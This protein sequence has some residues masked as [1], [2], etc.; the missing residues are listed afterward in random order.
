M[1]EFDEIQVER[2]N[3]VGPDGTLRFVLA[4]EERLPPPILGGEEVGKR[5]GDHG[6]MFV[7]YNQLGDECGGLSLHAEDKDGR[8]RARSMLL[9]DQ[10][11]S[12]EVL[13]VVY[14]HAQGKH[15]YGILAQEPLAILISELVERE[16]QIAELSD[17]T[18]RAE[19]QEQLYKDF[20]QHDRL[21]V[22]RT[23]DG[24][25]TVSLSDGAGRPRLR[26]LVGIDGD[27]RIEFL[28]EN[29]EVT[30]RFPPAV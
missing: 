13:G 9:L 21:F 22:G 24:A 19:A 28:D 27:P 10:F 30:H 2:L 29:G 26:M 14:D 1:E 18:A 12:N 20:A 25:A 3:V 4:N 16:R 11:R 15:T 7:F 8:T 23:S 6:P 5:E 17:E